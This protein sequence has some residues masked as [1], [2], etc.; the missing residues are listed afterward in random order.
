MGL[1]PQFSGY[2]HANLVP[3]V[4]FFLIG[5]KMIIRIFSKLKNILA[6]WIQSVRQAQVGWARSVTPLSAAR[7]SCLFSWGEKKKGKTFQCLEIVA[8]F[9][10]SRCVKYSTVHTAGYSSQQFE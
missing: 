9:F 6:E 7:G 10:F 1:Y 3:H 4:Q 2:T 5:E 8:V